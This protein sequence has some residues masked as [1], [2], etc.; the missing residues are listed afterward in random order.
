MDYVAYHSSEL[1]G[2]EMGDNQDFAMLSRKPVLHLAGKTI[3]VL[4][5]RGETKKQY[6]LKQRFEVDSIED[7]EDD[8]YRFRYSGRNGQ[9]FTPEIPLSSE[10]WFKDFMKAVANFS[11]GVTTLKP[12]YLARFEALTN[13]TTRPLSE[14]SWLLIE[15]AHREALR[16]YRTR[17]AA[18]RRRC[19]QHF[20]CKC[21]ACGFDFAIKYGTECAD[22][23][24]VHH[25]KSIATTDGEYQINPIEDLVPVCSNCH[26]VLH[27]LDIDVDS[28]IERIKDAA[29]E[30]KL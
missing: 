2:Y 1:M 11:I 15:G 28:L 20:G 19:I 30:P 17:S 3:W 13:S 10:V 24:E 9:N 4:E 14:E 5:G 21:A 16:T 26:S 6:F 25:R 12:E 23:I 22:F 27:L 7:V 18:A 29:S 8:H